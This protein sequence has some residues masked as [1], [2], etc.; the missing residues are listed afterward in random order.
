MTVMEQLAFDFYSRVSIFDREPS[1]RETLEMNV[2]KEHQRLREIE[3]RFRRPLDEPKLQFIGS[4]SSSPPGRMPV[5]R[6]TAGRSSE[7][8]QTA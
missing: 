1:L 6:E 4:S 3:S 8:E 7:L 5:A 2:Y